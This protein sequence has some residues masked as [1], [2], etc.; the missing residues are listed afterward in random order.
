MNVRRKIAISTWKPQKDCAMLGLIP[1]DM[2]NALKLIEEVNKNE[3]IKLTPTVLVGK[4]CAEALKEIPE[5]NGR[6]VFGRFIPRSTFDVCFLVAVPESKN[7]GYAT[8]RSVDKMSLSQIAE[9]VAKNA[10]NVRAGKDEAFKANLDLA[11]MMPT[12]IL[13]PIV[14]LAGFLGNVLGITIKPLGLNAN[15]FGSI[16]VTSIG[17]LGIE[18]AY[19]PFSPFFHVPAV[20]TVCAIKKKAMVVEND[21][22]EVRSMMNITFTVDH[23]LLD[24]L[25]SS[26]FMKKL[27]HL[28]THPEEMP[29]K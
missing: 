7:L 26:K 5:V 8:L 10:G 3:G 24:A 27:Q 23:R 16:V 14:H 4:A 1:I 15:A 25:E 6:I 28:L 19:A 17:T 13:N 20:A 12:I 18:E 22:I 29:L 2:T 11:R 21:K 9:G